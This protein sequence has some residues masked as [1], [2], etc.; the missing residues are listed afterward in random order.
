MSNQCFFD[1]HICR[2]P[3]CYNKLVYFLFIY[4]FKNILIRMVL[5]CLLNT[6]VQTLTFYFYA[7]NKKSLKPCHVH[8]KTISKHL[9]FIKNEILSTECYTWSVSVPAKTL[10][11]YIPITNLIKD[12]CLKSYPLWHVTWAPGV[13]KDS[14]INYKYFSHPLLIS[15]FK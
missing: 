14:T 13:L 6:S 9:G 8:Y 10:F 1:F 4:W 5:C 15:F 11:T 2:C 3:K 7:F 12:G